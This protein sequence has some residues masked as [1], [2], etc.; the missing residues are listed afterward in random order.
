MCVYKVC[1]DVLCTHVF[2]SCIHELTKPNLAIY[3]NDGATISVQRLG[4][5]H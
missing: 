5:H 3:V 1:A 2:V 4:R